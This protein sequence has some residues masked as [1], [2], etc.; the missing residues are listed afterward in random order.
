M[1]HSPR[2]KLLR[3]RFLLA[4]LLALIGAGFWSSPASEAATI[5]VNPG[6]TSPCLSSIQAAVN[7]ASSGDT[8]QIAAGTYN[9]HVLFS[10][11]LTITGAGAGST[12]VDGTNSG[13]VFTIPGATVT[14]SNLT[15]QHGSAS[16]SQ[17]GG[18]I[19]NAANL[20]LTNV[21]IINSFGEGG[22]IFNESGASLT[23]TGSTISGNSSVGTSAGGGFGGGI[24]SDGAASLTNVTIANNSASNGGGGIANGGTLTLVNSTISGNSGGGIGGFGGSTGLKATL[25]ANASNGGD[26]SSPVVS[27]GSNLDQDGT[28]RLVAPGDLSNIDPKLGPLANNGGSTQT[29]ALQA[30]SPA[31]DAVASSL[32]PPPATDQRGVARPQGPRCDI[33]AF[34]LASSAPPSTGTTV[35][36]QGGWNL[37]GGP[38]GTMLTG[39]SGALYTFQANDTNYE[40]F[41]TSTPI[42]APQGFWAFFSATTTVTLPTV[43]AQRLTVPL[44]ANHFIMVGN[45]GDTL[46][47]INGMDFAYTY[48]PSTGYVLATTLNPGQGA[49][50]FS[51]R[52]GTLTIANQ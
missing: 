4:L 37:V 23:I 46:A 31:I 5:C 35:T 26:C 22:G 41:S 42:Q 18:G 14:I 17:P 12:I 28:C 19:F 1:R 32:C 25:I 27:Q 52:G 9:E 10:T 16:A 2:S 24:A 43:S 34:E 44:P 20:T 30:G 21:A 45:P 40:T 13:T 51:A 48:S 47:T 38:T 6:G 15:I 11:N 7:A 50:V 39:I 36:Y 3:L 33:G 49:W 8:I 29:M